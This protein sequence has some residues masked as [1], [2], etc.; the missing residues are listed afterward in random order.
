MN[1]LIVTAHLRKGGPVDVIYNLCKEYKKYPEIHV[2]IATLR[3]ESPNS[4]INDFK[5]LG[6]EIIQLN[7]S[8]LKCEIHPQKLT[9]KIQEI[10]NKEKIDIINAHGYY[11]CVG[12]AALTGV[13][14]IS[15]LHNRANEDYINVYGRIIGN[16][17]LSH[18]YKA[19]YQY[20]LNV[21]VAKNAAGFYQKIIP[22]VTYVNNGIDTDKFGLL[23]ESKT[24]TL[25]EKLKLPY[26]KR[27]LISTGR[28]E[29][30]KRYEDLITWFNHLPQKE[31]LA[32]VIVGDGSRLEACKKLAEGNQNIYFTGRINN[33]A[34]YL[35][36]SD[37]FISYSKSE[38]MSMALCEAI[39][40]GLYPILSDIPSHHDAADAIGG[41]FYKEIQQIN[42]EEILSKKINKEELHQYI[43]DNFSIFTMGNGYINL[44][45]QLIG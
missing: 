34:E 29:K 11:A 31:F 4:K 24:N 25:K 15:T 16:Y 40:S 7:W 44:F 21:T 18:L 10:V 14:K 37:Y 9:A 19:L 43:V 6:M 27:I 32:L 1:L 2:K 17:M 3:A 5:K 42:M 38:G 23:E 30:E 35:Q 45:Q 33:V 12:C 41:Y 26:N 20:N 36:C 13:K 39:S 28:I 8:R 22:H